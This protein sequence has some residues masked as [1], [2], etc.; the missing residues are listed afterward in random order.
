M[1]RST[2]FSVGLFIALWGVAFLFVDKVQLTTKEEQKQPE[3][4]FRG[5]LARVSKTNVQKQKVIDP[6]E[7]AAF[8]MM[9]VGAVTMLYAVA[10]PK[11]KQE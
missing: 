2:F 4:G 8:T 6:P 11:K 1:M 9:S 3:T 7:W 10:L 5:F